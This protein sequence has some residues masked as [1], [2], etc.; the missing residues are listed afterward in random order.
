VERKV[1][2]DDGMKKNQMKQK[3]WKGKEAETKRDK[4]KLI[5]IWLTVISL[6][7]SHCAIKF[8]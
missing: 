5:I 2:N 1:R 7:L 6:F 4:M 3:E 8:P